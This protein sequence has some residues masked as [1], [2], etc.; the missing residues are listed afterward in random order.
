[1]TLRLFL[2]TNPIKTQQI[3]DFNQHEIIFQTLYQSR[4]GECQCD[5][6]PI[7][8]LADYGGFG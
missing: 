1:M 8:F 2:D 5:D 6:G 3:V 7:G 4:P